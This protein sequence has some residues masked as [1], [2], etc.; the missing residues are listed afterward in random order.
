MVRDTFLDEGG[1]VG[2]SVFPHLF[3]PPHGPIDLVFIS[4]LKMNVSNL[5]TTGHSIYDARNILIERSHFG[6]STNAD[7]AI[8]INGSSNAILDNLTCI[9]DADIPQVDDI[10][11]RLTVI[12]STYRELH[13]LA[14]TTTVL[15]TTP[16]LD[17]V[18]YVRAEFISALGRQPDPAAHFY[19]SDKLIRCAQDNNCVTQQKSSLS[20]YLASQPQPDFHCLVLSWMKTKSH[21]QG[22]S[23]F[24]RLTS[25]RHGIRFTRKVSVFEF[26]NQRKLHSGRCEARIRLPAV[27][28]PLSTLPET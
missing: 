12:N 21:C 15:E 23:Q 9:D 19:W 4:G 24:N 26:A 13:S 8:S 14:Q 27:V 6:W 10:T 22:N 7:S 28:R 17:P 3:N 2:I 18:Q 25:G 16:E 20:Q 11:Q 5:G 1:W